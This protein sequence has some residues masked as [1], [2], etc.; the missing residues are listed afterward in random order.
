MS[1]LRYRLAQAPLASGLR[2]PRKD[3]ILKT[4]V[5]AGL[6]N[7]TVLAQSPLQILLNVALIVNPP[8]SRAPLS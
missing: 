6:W 2:K 1:F 4:V 8:L 7:A 5:Q 3:P